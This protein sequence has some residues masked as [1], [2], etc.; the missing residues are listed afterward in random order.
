M[1]KP[2]QVLVSIVVPVYKVEK[3]ISR[4]IESILTQTHQNLE[5][6]LVNDGSPDNSG[7]IC[8]AYAQKDSRITVIHKENGGVSTARN[9]GIEQAQGKYLFFVDSDDW[10]E[11]DHVA[12]LLPVGNEDCVYGGTKFYVNGIFRE[13]RPMPSVLVNSEEWLSDYLHFT[14]RGLTLFFIHPCYKMSIIN[15]HHIRFRTG[16]HISED[17]LFNLDYMKHCSS[18]RYTSACTYCYED[19]DDTSTS[20]SHS[21]HPQRLDAEIVKCMATEDLTGK[22]EMTIRWRQWNGVIRHYQK[23]LHF[24]NGVHKT[25]ARHCLKRTYREPYF[26]A[27]I[28]HVRS[29]GTLDERLETYFMHPALH[30]LFKPTYSL[31]AFTSKIKRRILK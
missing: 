23:W 14:S 4:C 27:C 29:H 31:I 22:E 30:C 11:P 5:L 16:L 9:A 26:R 10:I 12:M 15:N 7:A 6:I 18:I 17:G 8:D 13:E 20:L 25:E 24:N 1:C 21:F 19:G 3:Q 28:S 2:D